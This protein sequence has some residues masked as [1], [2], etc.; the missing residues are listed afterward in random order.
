MNVIMRKKDKYIKKISFKQC[1]VKQTYELINA[2][3]RFSFAWLFDFIDF[4]I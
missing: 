4:D 1:T 2:V 3:Y